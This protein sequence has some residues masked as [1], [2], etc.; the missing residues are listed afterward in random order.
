MSNRAKA[1][2]TLYRRG[3]VTIDGLKK[4]VADGTITAGEY[5]CIAGVSYAA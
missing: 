2:Q 1:L 4:A 3:K 5:E